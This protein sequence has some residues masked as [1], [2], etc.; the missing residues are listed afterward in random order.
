M[1]GRS[2]EG[3]QDGDE[4]PGDHDTSEPFSGAPAFDD[5]AAGDFEEQI[6]DKENSGAETE[7]SIAEAQIVHHFERGVTDVNAIEEG[8]NEEGEQEWQESLSDAAPRA[9]A[10]VVCGS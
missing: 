7:D 5:E 4:S 8:D 2:N 10:D 1:S 3:H 9:E 6:A